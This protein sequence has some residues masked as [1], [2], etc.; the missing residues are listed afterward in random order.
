[1]L[2]RKINKWPKMLKTEKHLIET[3]SLT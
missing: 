1:L 3:F 2:K